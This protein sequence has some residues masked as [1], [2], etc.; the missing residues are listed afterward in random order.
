[1][2]SPIRI[3]LQLGSI[4]PY[5]V[6]V[7]ET[8]WRLCNPSSLHAALFQDGPM[9]VGQDL[10]PVELLEVEVDSARTL[11]DDGLTKV[12][13]I[14]ALELDAFIT[15]PAG[16]LLVNEL[17]ANG[18]PVVGLIHRDICHPLFTSPIELGVSAEVA[19]RF[20]ADRLSGRGRVL[21]LGGRMDRTNPEQSS[22]RLIYAQR[23][24]QE[25]PEIQWEHIPAPW[26]YAGARAAL[27]EALRDSSVLYDAV[28]GL[29]DTLALVAREVGDALSVLAPH[30]QIVGINGD[31]MAMAAIGQ[32]SMAATVATSASAFAREA[33]VMA[34]KAARGESLPR[35]FTYEQQLVTQENVAEVAMAK[36]AAI[37][38][39]PN[40][41]VGVNRRL[42]SQ[43][44]IQLEASLAINR[45]IGS[46]LDRAALPHEIADLI[47]TSYGYDQVQ[48]F[49]WNEADQTLLLDRL[50][51]GE[52]TEIRI[53]LADSAGLG[54]ALLTNRPVFIPD[55]HSSRR[56]AP[57]PYWPSTRSRVIVPVRLGTTTLGVLD[58]HSCVLRRHTQAELDALQTLADQL[59]VAM[60]NAEFYAD[61]VAARTEAERANHLKTRLLTNVSHELRT[62]LNVI[63]GYSQAALSDP[64]LYSTGLSP[65]LVNDLT[66][67]RNSGQHLVRLIN[68]LLDLS[69]AEIG[70][71]DIVVEAVDVQALLREVFDSAAHSQMGRAA[72]KWRLELSDDLPSLQADPV[73]LRQILLNLLSNA[74][75]FTRTG[76]ITLGATVLAMPAAQSGRSGASDSHLHIWVEDTGVGIPQA[77]QARIFEAFTAAQ[78]ADED[79]EPTRM[80]IGL[81]LAVTHHLV[82]LHGGRIGIES[83]AGRGTICHVYLPLAETESSVG[84]ALHPLGEDDVPLESILTGVVDN[85]SD[86]VQRAARFMQLN[87]DQMITSADL[88]NELGVSADYVARLFRRE[89]G[90]SPRQY[91]NRYR[92]VAAQRLL[93]ADHLSVTEIA[94]EVGFNDAAYFSRIF[95]QETGKSPQA[96]RKNAN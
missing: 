66:H 91:L 57:D 96:F 46:I 70:A 33:V 18:L 83:R 54:R 58:L 2:Q 56:F 10:P 94:A 14:L 21:L 16:P 3:G 26:D 34:C 88:A 13:E 75:K 79:G 62:P 51:T 60:R 12:E 72:V 24:F 42:E 90:M 48:L 19:C 32:G 25:F 82:K 37:A 68:D 40:R 47:R 69:Q 53:P 80:G 28:F 15:V 61:A 81:G 41:L 85:S 49:L 35:T 23:V 76:H 67:I 74:A 86:L 29:S 55:T 43:R 30:V 17:L 93:L 6:E 1:M 52:G 11:L 39:M 77:V 65:D 9:A 59:G 71:L 64:Q 22:S 7:R 45:R 8:I 4:D 20:L 84:A 78:L 73:R 36:L 87:H 95:R 44:L 50:R 5:W 63:L 38:D 31:P 89:T 27:E 92:M